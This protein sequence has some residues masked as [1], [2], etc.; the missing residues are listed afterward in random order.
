MRKSPVRDPTTGV[1]SDWWGDGPPETLFAAPNGPA[2]PPPPRSPARTRRMP[3]PLALAMPLSHGALSRRERASA[4]SGQGRSSYSKSRGDHRGERESFSHHPI[5]F[6]KKSWRMVNRSCRAWTDVVHRSMSVLRVPSVGGPN[7]SQDG[8][9]RPTDS[10]TP[11]SR[12]MSVDPLLA[13]PREP[14]RFGSV[15]ADPKA[16]VRRGRGFARRRTR[17]IGRPV[18]GGRGP[19]TVEPR[20]RQGASRPHQGGCASDAVETGAGDRG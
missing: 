13:L 19:W 15:G 12:A 4:S 17:S 2:P 9:V 1:Q 10:P 5:F 18:L 16:V 7:R 20:G 14:V 3:V 6:S 11:R 8:P